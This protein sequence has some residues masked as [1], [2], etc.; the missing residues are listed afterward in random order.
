MH[1][2]EAEDTSL[3]VYKQENIAVELHLYTFPECCSTY[4]AFMECLLYTVWSA[5]WANLILCFI[6]FNPHPSSFLH[7]KK[8]W[9]VRQA[10]PMFKPS[11]GLLG[12]LL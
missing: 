1:A 2:G 6:S 11:L 10:E 7:L 3:Q 5:V 12:A 4:L 8:V 9:L